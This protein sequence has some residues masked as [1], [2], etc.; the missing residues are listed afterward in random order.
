MR[1]KCH[2]WEVNCHGW[3]VKCMGT[4]GSKSRDSLAEEALTGD[5]RDLL[6]EA[7]SAPAIAGRFPGT[8]MDLGSLA[9]RE[10]A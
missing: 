6:D 8:D 9:S 7:A 5:R 3:E 10:K 4:W 1:V 2:G